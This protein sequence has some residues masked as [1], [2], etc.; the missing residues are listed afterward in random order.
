MF[1]SSID[2]FRLALRKY[3][4]RED[5]KVIRDKNEKE[6]GV[7]HC[8]GE[9]CKWWIHASVAPDGISFM[10]KTYIEK[11][12]CVRVDKNKEATASWMA[13]KLVDVLRENPNMKCRG[14]RSYKSLV[15]IHHICSFYKA[16]KIAML[17]IEGNHATSFGMLTKYVEMASRTNPG[18]IFK[19]QYAHEMEYIPPTL[20]L[21][22]AFC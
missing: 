11:H 5:F 19:L 3:A 21:K 9:R 17:S 13:E 4:I 22:R 6:G 10:I 15:S 14:M 2:T 16:K 12:T 18:S 8:D 20:I 7:V 1:F